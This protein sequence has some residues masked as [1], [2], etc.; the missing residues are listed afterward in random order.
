MYYLATNNIDVFHFGFL[1]AGAVVTT[2]QPVVNYYDTEQELIDA[3]SDLTG[4]PNYYST[5]EGNMDN[6]LFSQL[7]LDPFI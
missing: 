4:D 5:H 3:L 2:G 1:A 7:P 6:L